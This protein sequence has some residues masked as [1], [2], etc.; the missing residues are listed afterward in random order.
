MGMVFCRGCGKEIHETAPMCPHCGFQF[1][2]TSALFGKNS[3]WLAVTSSILSLL[4]FLNWFGVSTWTTDIKVGLW[5]FCI[6][7][8]ALSSVSLAQQHRGKIFNYISI[9][10]SAITILILIGKI[11]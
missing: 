7:A 4:S 9:C 6:V 10:V 3:I 8:I 1:S 11:T 2:A 5:L